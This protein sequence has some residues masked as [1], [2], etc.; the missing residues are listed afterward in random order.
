MP[1]NPYPVRDL[2]KNFQVFNV[3]DDGETFGGADGS[4][5]LVYPED[6]KMNED[7]LME[8][9]NGVLPNEGEVATICLRKLLNEAMLAKLDC[10]KPLLKLLEK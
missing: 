10:V 7:D 6:D 9:E 2:C 8:L 4:Q 5:I 1:K 3:L